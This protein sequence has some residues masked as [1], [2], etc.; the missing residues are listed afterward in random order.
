MSWRVVVVEAR[1]RRGRRLAAGRR[2]RSECEPVLPDPQPSCTCVDQRPP[3]GRPSS[4]PSPGWPASV[5]PRTRPFVNR[6]GRHPVF[7]RTRQ[8]EALYT[9]HTITEIQWRKIL[10]LSPRR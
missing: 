8:T 2:R 1:W 4:T 10:L 6:T 3:A 7:L 9:K 5:G